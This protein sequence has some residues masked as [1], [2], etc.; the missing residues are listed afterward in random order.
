MLHVV[1]VNE[2][3]YLVYRW[4]T[5]P[6]SSGLSR[7]R[8]NRLVDEAV[9]YVARNRIPGRRPK[10]DRAAVL[11]LIAREGPWQWSNMVRYRVES[12]LRELLATHVRKAMSPRFVLDKFSLIERSYGI[13]D[14]DWGQDAFRDVSGLRLD[15]VP[16]DDPENE[17]DQY[18]RDIPKGPVTV[19][20]LRFAFLQIHFELL[21][22][23]LLKHLERWGDDLLL[24]PADAKPRRPAPPR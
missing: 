16:G 1:P 20:L 17:E 5:D 10:S 24:P 13:C 21:T 18:R 3:T 11:K 14:S 6:E 15:E 12:I 2:A 7:E 19:V 22:I 4:L 9:I 8:L 23:A